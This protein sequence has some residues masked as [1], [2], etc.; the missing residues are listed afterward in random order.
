MNVKHTLIKN[1]R[2]N[3]KVKWELQLCKYFIKNLTQPEAKIL[4]NSIDNTFTVEIV[5]EVGKG[6]SIPEQ[7]LTNDR[8]CLVV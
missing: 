8:W 4:E 6:A 5:K 7:S 3:V 2:G 1:H